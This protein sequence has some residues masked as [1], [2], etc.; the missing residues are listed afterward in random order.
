MGTDH[1]L[2]W[3]M[4]RIIRLLDAAALSAV[5]LWVAACRDSAAPTA[6]TAQFQTELV[7]CEASVPAGT[8]TCASSQPQTSR[9]LLA[10]PGMSF[11]L[12]LGGQGALVRLAS[13]GTAYNAGTQAFTSNVTV[14]NLIAQPMNTTNGTTPDAGGIKVFLHSGPAVTGGTGTVTI[15]NADGT[16]TFTGASQPYF[17]YSSGAVLASGATTS[18]KTWQFA[19]PTTVTTF[20]FQVFVTTRL[21]DETSALVALGLSRSPS[22]LTIVQGLTGNTTVTLTRTNLTGAVTLSLGSAPAGVTGSFSPA[23][24]TGTSSTLTVSVGAAVA[25]G[26]Y[27]LTVDGVGSPGSR[28]TPLTLTVS[29][30]GD[31][32]LSL[33]PAELTVEQGATGTATVTITRTNFTGAVSL[34]LSNAPTGVTGSFDPAAPT[35]TSSTLT[36]HVGAAVAPGVYNL[37]V[38]GTGT[39]GNRSTPL[40]LTVS[41]AP[42]YALSVAPAALTI[43]QGAN[44]STTVTITRTNFS[45]AVTLSL[46]NAPT[47]VTGSFDPATPTGTSST[48]TVGVGA[49]VAPGVYNLTVTGTAT[50]G[51]R[52]TPLTLTVSATPDYA[53]SLSPAALTIV[54]GMTGTATVTVTRTNF[55]GAVT[56]SLGGAAAV[57][58]PAFN[59][60]APTGTSSTLT[61]SVGAAVAPG[62]YNLTVD[63]TGTPGNRSTPLTLTVSG[64]APRSLINGQTYS[65]TISAP[66]ELHTWTFT[67]AAGDYIALSIGEVAP[68]SADFTP[69]IRLVSPT[70]TILANSF[71]VSAA[72][73]AVTAPASGTYSVVVGT[74]DPGFDAT[75]S[76]LLTLAKA[77]GVFETSAGDEGGPMTNGATHAGTIYLGDLDQWSFTAT[78]GDYIALSMGEVA[79]A[80]AGF[81]PWIR[82]VSPTGVLLGNG[83]GT[84]AV[85]IAATAPTSGT[86]T[87]IVGTNDG[88]VSARNNDTGSYLLTLAKG[89][90]T[91]ATSA[92]DE[93][94]PMTNGATH[95][96]TIY[97][98]DLDQWSFTATQGDYIALSM[99]EV[100]PATAGFQPWIRLVSPTGVLLGNG[101]GTSAVQ[102]AATAPTSGTY[103]VIVGT[104]DGTVSARNNDTGSYLLTLAKGPGTFAT[105][106]G[107]EGGPMTNGATHA[108]TIYL[109]DLDQWSFTATQ[110][111][112]IALSMGEVAPATAGFQP[113]IRLVSPTGVL[114][115]NGIGT[116]AVQ[117]AA[118]APTSGTYTVIVGTNDG[119]V[120]ARNDDT[121]SYLL[122][123]AK[124][125]GTFATSTGDEGGDLPNGAT[126]AGTIYL[127]DLD[128]WSFTAT[129]GDY[130]ALSM[131]EVAPA[132]AGFQPWIRLV[133]PTGVLLGNGIGTSAVQIAATAPTSGTYTVIVG[134]NDGTVSARNDDTGS[135]LL[136][137][138]KGPGTFATSTGDEG[139]DLPNGATQ[140]GT[141]YLGDLDQW[142]FTATQ[143]DYIALSMGEVAPATAGFQPWIRLVSPT[144]VLLGNGIGTSAV[145]IAA[146]APTSGTYTVIVGTNDGTVSARNNDTGSYLLTLAKGP[147][148]FA[149]SAGDEGGP[150]TNGAT[151]AGTIYLGDLD[152]WSFTATQGAYIALSMG[153][154]APATAGFQPWIRLVSPTGVLLG[155]GIGTSAV[156][157][158]ATAPTSGTYTV[159]VG[160]ND[161][162]VSARNNDTGSYLLTLAKG[163]GTF[164]TSAGDE[165]GPMTNGATHAGTIYLGDLDQW[166]FTATQG[167]YIALSMGEVAPATAGF[168]PWIRL[169]SPTGVLLGNG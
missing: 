165:G 114:L 17:L 77:P 93:G 2:R 143:G 45:G 90:G 113:W 34:S 4:L 27:N 29:A 169:V 155:N 5:A 84:S 38:D 67:A 82:L 66:G 37:T 18:A 118:T 79:P 53:L 152:Q 58:A 115:G 128:Q 133:S 30:V 49:A 119:T 61:V 12:I 132:T 24:P 43:G 153:E 106:A 163:P 72:Q 126:Q 86:Y 75:G 20:A 127:G 88:T 157:I 22:A 91:F 112:Y 130:I 6:P 137:L 32:T 151:H 46:G 147:G 124:G 92:G 135:Y 100:A 146:T 141:I 3:T 36:V 15:A 116:S 161:G 85:Q 73:L 11:D 21:P 52:S 62:V 87:V 134:T 42:D 1:R 140:A 8:L 47:G 60:A 50:A 97:L 99:G 166:S 107:D 83:I 65:G 55:T 121:G 25:P 154:V 39:P 164:A 59:P 57:V 14:E 26:V 160:T 156:Q 81:Q 111:D 71:G 129:Q 145:Q 70:G 122:T 98:G 64:S 51:N 63:G 168:Q 108:G 117:I 7:T 167:D 16:G 142:S 68:A 40:T 109:G 123:L 120:S 136:T 56:L 138:A 33:T 144:G 102:I 78:Q 158:A 69:W 54:Q 162:T 89:P 23:A 110:G 28:S 19:V 148:T 96:G 10:A 131:G 76:Y 44:G 125:P 159:I 94:G 101:I 74:N 150:M 95:A 149:T 41:A 35:A 105:S 139:G 103:T 104:N 13:S 9:Q 80:T 31:Y 48:L